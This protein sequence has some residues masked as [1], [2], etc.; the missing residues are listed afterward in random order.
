[1]AGASANGLTMLRFFAAAISSAMGGSYGQSGS[2]ELAEAEKA[3]A[4]MLGAPVDERTE[5]TKTAAE[6]SQEGDDGDDRDS[7]HEEKDQ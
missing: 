1:V 4:E 6:E 5:A 7:D 3:K 2:E